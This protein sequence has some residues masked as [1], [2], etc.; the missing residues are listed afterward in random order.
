L[1]TFP[2]WLGEDF[3]GAQDLIPQTMDSTTPCETTCIAA[4]QGIVR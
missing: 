1:P 2:A 3:S 4:V